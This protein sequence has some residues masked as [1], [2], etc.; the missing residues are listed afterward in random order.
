MH[1]CCVSKVGQTVQPATLH[2]FFC[3]VT[4]HFAFKSS[5]CLLHVQASKAPLLFRSLQWLYLCLRKGVPPFYKKTFH[6]AY[7]QASDSPPVRSRLTLLLALLQI[8]G[9]RGFIEVAQRRTCQRVTSLLLA[10]SSQ[11]CLLLCR[12]LS[13][14]CRATFPVSVPFPWFS[15][16]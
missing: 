14:L 6:L 11:C 12:L 8:S 16:N 5:T 1:A 3:M 2:N 13:A 9:A 10:C 15:N 7:L 4:A